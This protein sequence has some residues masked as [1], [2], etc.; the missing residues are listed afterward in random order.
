MT[1]MN[2]EV[3]QLGLLS[4]SEAVEVLHLLSAFVFSSIKC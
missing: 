2:S 1:C 4:S 3:E